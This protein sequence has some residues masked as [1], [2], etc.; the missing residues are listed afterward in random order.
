MPVR[1]AAR[2]VVV[3]AAALLVVCLLVAGPLWGP[4]L[5]NTR[6]GGDS[7][8]LLQRT[9]QL[10]KNLQAGILPARWMPDAAYG[11]G[12]PFFSYYAALPYY[13]A[14]GWVLIGLDVLSAVKLTQTLCLVA[15]ALAMYGWA[16]NLALGRTGALLAATAYT[17]APFHLA[18]LYVRG[19]SLSEFAAFAL[20]PLILWGLDRLSE[21]PSAGRVLLPALAYAGLVSTHNL[22]ALMFSP[23][24]VLYAA[25]DA[26]AVARRNRPPAAEAPL[27]GG[28]SIRSAVA[29]SAAALLLG[30]LLSAW[31]WVPALGEMD[32]VQL[33]AQTTGYFHYSNHFRAAD[34]VQTSLFFN[35]QIGPDTA[36]PF[37]MG[38]VQVVLT[39]AGCFALVVR[40]ARSSRARRRWDGWAHRWAFVLGGF[41]LATF[42]ITPLSRPAW[43]HL[44][45]LDMVQFPWRFLS[46]QS[47]FAAVLVGSLATGKGW[48]GWIVALVLTAVLGVAQL[49][50]LTPEYLSIAGEE[51]TA[52]RLQLYEAFTGNVGTTVRHEYLPRWVVPRPYT[53]PALFDPDGEPA[54]I[55]LSGVL[56]AAE[57]TERAPTRRTWTVAAGD[58]G[59]EVALPVYYWPGW[60]ATVDGLPIE[61]RPA[62]DLGYASLPVQAGDHSIVVWLDRTPLRMAAEAVSL[63]AGLVALLAVAADAR[64]R[65]KSGDR[66]RRNDRGPAC[67]RALLIGVP[68]AVVLALLLL[69]SPRVSPQEGD[70]TMDFASMPYL[71]H[72]PI[73]VAV[74]PARLDSYAYSADV[75]SPGSPIAVALHWQEPV[76]GAQAEIRLEALG[77]VGR[78]VARDLG[79][80]TVSLDERVVTATLNLSGALEPG[81]GLHVVSL[82]VSQEGERGQSVDRVYLRPV[83][84]QQTVPSEQLATLDGG[85]SGPVLLHEGSSAWQEGA[86]HLAVALYWSCTRPVG[87]NYGLAIR[88]LDSVGNEWIKLDTQPGYGFL[89]TSLWPAGR[90]IPDCYELPLP[91]GIPP[92][93]AYELRASLYRVSTYEAGGEWSL[94]VVLELAAV[95]P[96]AP[97]VASFGGELALSGL[98]APESVRQGDQLSVTA[99]WSVLEGM[100]AD[101]GAEWRL[102]G[103]EKE[104]EF[105]LPLAAGA[106]PS[107]W[108][109]GAYVAGRA[110]LAIPSLAPPGEYLLSVTVTHPDGGALGTYVCPE[111]LLVLERQRAWELPQMEREVGARFGD[112]IELAGY[113]LDQ[114]G[115]QLELALH[116]RALSAPDRDYT[117][118]VH[119]ADPVTGHPI[120]QIDSMPRGYT[121]PTG[122]WVAGEV[123]SDEVVL[124]LQDVPAGTYE[125]AVGWY[126]ADTMT[127]LEATDSSGQQLADDRLILPDAV[128]AR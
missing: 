46:I 5:I 19:D 50:K 36:S 70:L 69:F 114:E 20:Y 91:L 110:S 8:F 33:T 89:A 28:G 119:L 78:D 125:L 52:E 88:L 10:A 121:Y 97:V 26:A 108:P 117:F 23:F 48:R 7:P 106:V 9:H 60:R 53:G 107:D 96:D 45:L 37:A 49:G 85:G 112:L 109:A 15:A 66:S 102:R 18:N 94:P 42:C 83:W 115:G 93:E 87:A 65:A 35:Y 76:T 116:W 126:W 32:Y 100:S 113:D 124:Q 25:L 55:A 6:A 74:G 3:P 118:F 63:I 34:L 90:V 29:W 103:G 56:L 86:E 64:A 80:A 2:G 84:V 13:L 77:D 68:L 21:R 11:L 72:N 75:I 17:L 47:L 122:L 79:G 31:Y 62:A 57:E 44:P 58:G 73:G 30:I 27:E 99:Y 12:Y 14:G 4:G 101:Y 120:A 16:R 51:V 41:L 92:G 40:L 61:L 24:V 105:S 54:A 1:S 128:A 98:E 104:Y 95:L 111:P 38:L 127:R 81:P 71:H 22:S 59:A 43:D 123:V 82:G 39:V 67:V